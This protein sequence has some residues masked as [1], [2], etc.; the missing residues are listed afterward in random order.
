MKIVIAPDSYKESLSAL[1]VAQLIQKGF[2]L[3][4]PMAEYHLVPIADGGEGTI[5]AVIRATQGQRVMLSVMGPLGQ[6]VEASYA[7]TGDGKSAVIEMAE[8]SGLAHVPLAQ[9]DPRITTSFGTGEL[10]KD[11]LARG[12]RH[13][14]LGL[15][16]SATNDGGAG[17]L[18]ALGLQLLDAKGNLLP[19]GGLS[20][21]E[22]AFIDSSYFDPAI[23]EC[24]FEVA[25]D[26]DTVLIG[27]QGASAIFGPQKGA[28]AEMVSQ[29]DN[30][31]AHYAKIVAQTLACDVQ[32]I[33][34]HVGSGAAGGMG[35][36]A[37]TFLQGR[38]RPGITLILDLINFAA[39]IAD[40]DLVITG[41]GK[42]DRQ[43]LHGKAPIGVARIAKAHNIP[44]IAIA[45]SLGDGAHL[46]KEA[47]VDALVSILNSP[48]TLE[49]AYLES[50]KN[51]EQTAEN[52]AA[53]LKVGKML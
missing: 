6:P 34:N 36:A 4:Y 48:C 7:I 11:A 26:V 46:V 24:H 38:L 23:K 42:I 40:A 27:E 9:R 41:E 35:F 29:L 3:H 14:I 49:E 1:E 16:G 22:L 31:L 2:S 51:L 8:A 39:L 30:A 52:V 17:M 10:I 53:I 32:A 33:Q 20:L 25:C 47:G 43:T 5:D 45:G 13:I 50:R 19:L 44:V 15:G 12:I 21:K 37:L 28:T 18:A